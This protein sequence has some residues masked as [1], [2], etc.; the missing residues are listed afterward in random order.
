MMARF[1]KMESCIT[2]VQS[3]FWKPFLACSP[4]PERDG[5]DDEDDEIDN[6]GE[7][8]D[9]EGDEIDDQGDEIDDEDDETD[10]EGDETDDEGDE[11]DDDN[12]T[13]EDV[14][15]EFNN[16]PS[17]YCSRCKA[18]LSPAGLRQGNT[19]KGFRH[20]DGIERERSAREGCPLCMLLI[21]ALYGFIYRRDRSSKQLVFYTMIGNMLT[22]FEADTA[23]GGEGMLPPKF[24]GL[25]GFLERLN[26]DETHAVTLTIY[27]AEGEQSPPFIV[28]QRPEVKRITSA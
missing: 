14:M 17:D 26:R 16:G 22:W 18:M 8:I 7:E 27:T 3:A 4:H 13:D 11:T 23:G 9:N 21:E 15:I 25:M 1:I 6:E 5:T 28:P 19:K 10:D 24:D 2:T 20:Y 12:D